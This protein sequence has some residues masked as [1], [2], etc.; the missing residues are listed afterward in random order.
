MQRQ[1]IL[2]NKQQGEIKMS[3]NKE[4]MLMNPNT[5]SIASVE[6]WYGDYVEHKQKGIEGL[7]QWHGFDPEDETKTMEL[8][9][10]FFWDNDLIQVEN[11]NGSWE[12]VK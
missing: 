2:T 5:G 1:F 3:D 12:E 8:I 9:E 4:K 10:E 7:R 11:N 6:E